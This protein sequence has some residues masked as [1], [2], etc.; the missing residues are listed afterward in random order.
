MEITNSRVFN[1]SRE[2]LFDAFADP[3]K[4]ARWWGPDGFT[5][6]FHKFD[7]EPGGTWHFTMHASDG[8]AFENTSTFSEITKPER[9]A[10]VHHLPIHVFTMTMTYAAEATGTRLTWLMQF[11]PSADNAAIKDFIAAANEQNFDRLETLLK[12]S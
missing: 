3:D 7:F 1:A 10:F 8:S 9:I 12:R 6:T 4:L 5:N 2:T 11:E